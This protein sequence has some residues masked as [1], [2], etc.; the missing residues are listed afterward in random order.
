MWYILQRS[1]ANLWVSIV[2]LPGQF[3]QHHWMHML[4]GN[5]EEYR[6]EECFVAAMTVVG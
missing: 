3:L 5:K 6:L 1:R 4:K 2:S